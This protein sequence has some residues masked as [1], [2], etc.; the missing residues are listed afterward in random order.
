M[1]KLKELTDLIRSEIKELTAIEVGQIFKSKFDGNIVATRIEQ[2]T[3]NTYSI[4]GFDV[5]EG[6]PRNN[7]Y[8]RDLELVG[9]EIMLN[10]VLHWHSKKS[11]NKYSHFEVSNGEGYFVIYD[12]EEAESKAWDLSKPYLKDQSEETIKFLCNLAGIK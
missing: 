6:L 5:K 12:E 10:N 9:K 1:D 11:R 3:A 7:C 2:H 8:P 4:Y